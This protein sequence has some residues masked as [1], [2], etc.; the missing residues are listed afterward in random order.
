MTALS[1]INHL[2]QQHPALFRMDGVGH[3]S[4][5]RVPSGFA[6]LDASL[7]GGWPVSC[8]IEVMGD[9][10]G[11][12]ELSLLLPT[13][14]RLAMSAQKK[15]ML[16]V[17]PLEM[18]PRERRAAFI[19]YAPALAAHGVDVTQLAI[20]NTLRTDETLW[21]V[22]QALLSG[23]VHR[24]IAWTHESLP[25]VALRRIT[26]AA[27]RSECLTFLMRPAS[28][29]QR[30][31]PAPVRVRVQAAAHGVLKVNVL[32]RRGLL[33]EQQISLNTRA[34]PCLAESREPIVLPSS[35][36]RAEKS[37][38]PIFSE[39]SATVRARPLTAR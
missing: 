9:R 20:V 19:P 15:R 3:A 10:L 28:A 13:Q 38:L 33:S 5:E 18:N 1:K 6:P 26:Y 35:R 14:A 29:S 27:Q 2:L 16:W 21:V 25:D 36:V 39:H 24:L 17:V 4:S 32:K 31:S 30:A 34:L 22:E 37:S 11:I 23:A 12:G 7:G 8:L